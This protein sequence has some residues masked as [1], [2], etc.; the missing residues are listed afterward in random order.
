MNL[1]LVTGLL[2]LVGLV[3]IVVPVLPGLVLVWL[4]TALWAYDHPAPLAWAVFGAATL[5]YV[6]GV[7]TQYVIPGQR[8]RRAGVGTGTL[9][10]AVVLAVV[11]FFV[12][13][14]VGAL[15]GFVLGIFLV[16][17]SRRHDRGAAWSAT[18][19]ALKGM[20]LSMGIE[21]LTGFAIIAV[22]V[23]GLLTLGTGA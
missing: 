20:A 12:V 8:M 5:L 13:P 4:S 22:W 11:G 17:L 1:T 15:I 7:V 23:V 6:A 2:M 19:H 10:L 3:G 18:Q 16:E 14:V 9:L 21:L